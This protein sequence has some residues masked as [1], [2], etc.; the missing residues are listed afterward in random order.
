MT[1]NTRSCAS[2]PPNDMLLSRID[3]LMQDNAGLLHVIYE[4]LHYMENDTS[5]SSQRRF[6]I[7]DSLR[8]ALDPTRYEKDSTPV[9]TPFSKEKS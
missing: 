1:V 2:V 7:M 5:Y 9:L 6:E 3:E 8:F 4:T